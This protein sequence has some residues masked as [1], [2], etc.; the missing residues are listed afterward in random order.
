MRQSYYSCKLDYVK[1]SAND[2]RKKGHREVIANG[3]F[4]SILH[5]IP[6]NGN[7]LLIPCEWELVALR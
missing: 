6:Q 2:S 3:I 1:A 4:A 7:I 5:G